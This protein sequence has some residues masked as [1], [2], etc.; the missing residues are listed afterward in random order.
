MVIL[1]EGTRGARREKRA[2]RPAVRALCSWYRGALLLSSYI[3]LIW[4]VWVMWASAAALLVLVTV[5]LAPRRKVIC[6][7]KSLGRCSTLLCCEQVVS[8][9]TARLYTAVLRSS[10]VSTPNAGESWKGAILG[11]RS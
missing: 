9:S 3:T 7:R 5:T 2:V 10:G 4:L 8:R 1:L 11:H 6:R